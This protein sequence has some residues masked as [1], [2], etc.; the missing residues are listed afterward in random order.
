[1]EIQLMAIRSAFSTLLGVALALG[2]GNLSYG[3]TLTLGDPGPDGIVYRWTVSELGAADNSGAMVRHV[4]ALSFNDPINAGDPDG[5]GWTHTSDWVAFELLTPAS[6]SIQLDRTPGVPNGTDV[7]GD[8]LYPAFALYSG[9]D[10]DD[11]DHHVYNNSGNFGWAEDLNYIGN[12]PNAGGATSV[13]KSFDLVAGLYSIAL[14]GNPPGSIG[15]GRQGYTATITTQPVPEPSALVL[16][17][18]SVIALLAA[19]GVRRRSSN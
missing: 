12:E 1:M 10:N 9:W 3:A 6:V 16:G 2:A 18:L 14:G 11:G 17:G 5:T 15:S 13:T 8:Q 4:G 7:A 19:R